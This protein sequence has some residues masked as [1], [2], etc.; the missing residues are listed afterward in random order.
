ME[1]IRK[2]AD[3]PL[4]WTQPYVTCREYKLRCPD[5]LLAGL[6][7]PSVWS[8]QAE[9][10]TVEG[11]WLLERSG[12]MKPR[13]TAIVA[14]SNAEV[15]CLELEWGGGTAVFPSGSRYRWVRRSF[16]RGEWA[17]VD[18]KDDPLVTFTPQPGFFKYQLAVRILPRAIGVPELP[19][20]TLLGCYTL[21][22]QA[23]DAAASSAAAVA[24]MG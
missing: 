18:E 11:T 13:I 2:F 21:I 20:L 10:E 3:Q 4:T 6:R 1:S 14:K 8:S 5:G 19:L 9:G 23:H 16:W 12:W 15:G 24:A 7:W 17:F 22:L